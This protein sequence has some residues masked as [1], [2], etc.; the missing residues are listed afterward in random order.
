MGMCT[1]VQ[2]LLYSIYAYFFHS[3]ECRFPH[4][5]PD[6]PV[7]HHQNHLGSRSGIS[8]PRPSNN[9][10]FKVIEEKFGA[11]TLQEVSITQ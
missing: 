4:V 5:M 1:F 6:G 3:D 7:P 8:R 2:V 9:H 11:M 10:P